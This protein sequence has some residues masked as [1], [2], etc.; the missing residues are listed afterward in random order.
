MEQISIVFVESNIK[1][2]IALAINSPRV[3]YHCGGKMIDIVTMRKSSRQTN[4][5]SKPA[6]RQH[7]NEK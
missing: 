7:V 6:T 2:I 1:Q 3:S 4:N 5:K